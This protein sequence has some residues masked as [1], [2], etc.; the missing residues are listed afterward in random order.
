MIIKKLPFILFLLLL[1][2]IGR[3]YFKDLIGLLLIFE[4][5]IAIYVVYAIAKSITRYRKYNKSLNRGFL[6]DMRTILEPRLGKGLLLEVV[7][8]ELNVLYYAILVWF[9]K[10]TEE[11]QGIY[12]YDKSSQIKTFV[13]VFSIL[14]IGEGV[15]FHFLIQKW[16][17]IAAWIFT[18]LN[19]YAV[20]YMIGLYNSFRSK[21]HVIKDGKITICL[22]FQS[23]IHM[24]L[25]NIKSMHKAKE[26][27][28][29]VK[30]PKDTYY[31]LLKIDS[32]QIELTLNQPT[33][34][35]AAYGRNKYVNTI[36]FRADEPNRLIG[37]TTL[38]DW[39]MFFHF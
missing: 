19:L 23:S 11:T 29:G 39:Q 18:V 31:A 34:L 17:D 6:E 12:T 8:T 36:I 13:I 3:T 35:R 20:L 27:E 2:V 4:I 38:Q 15:L 16:N 28:F 10:P 32:P 22:G 37:L 25:T 26:S 33:L 9:H 30:I 7:L 1:I 14:I 5:C 24:D 21:P